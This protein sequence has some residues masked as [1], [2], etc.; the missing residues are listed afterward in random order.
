M[1]QIDLKPSKLNRRVLLQEIGAAKEEAP[2]RQSGLNS[3]SSLNRAVRIKD[4]ARIVEDN[5]LILKKLSTA[6]SFYSIDRW[7]Q[8]DKRKQQLV[9]MLCKNS[10]R[11][12]KNP[13]FLHSLATAASEQNFYNSNLPCKGRYVVIDYRWWVR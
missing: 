4:M 3:Y 11:F 6:N 8:D 10:D 2:A 12:C 1:L 7:D 9:R 13:Y 5:K